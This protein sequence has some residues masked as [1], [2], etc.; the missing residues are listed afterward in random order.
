MIV[1]TLNY[2]HNVPVTHLISTK[3]VLCQKLSGAIPSS[4]NEYLSAVT[5][6][7]EIM[8]L[9]NVTKTSHSS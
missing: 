9:K 8:L 3:T 5:C 2:C 6:V 7:K 4:E 1:L